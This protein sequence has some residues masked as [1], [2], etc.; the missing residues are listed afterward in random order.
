M[1]SVC[2]GQLYE[3]DEDNEVAFAHSASAQKRRAY[4]V[5][6]LSVPL[7]RVLSIREGPLPR[8]SLYHE[9]YLCSIKTPHIACILLS[10]YIIRTC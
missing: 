9:K 7:D 6:H 2:Y 1:M 10:G 3:V 5:A 4:V 8:Y